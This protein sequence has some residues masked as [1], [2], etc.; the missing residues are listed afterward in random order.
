MCPAV[1]AVQNIGGIGNVTFLPPVDVDATPLAFDTGPG[2]ASIDWAALQATAGAQTFIATARWPPRVGWWRRGGQLA[3]A[4]YFAQSPPKTTG[5]ELFSAELAQTW[6]AAA[7]EQQSNDP[8]FVA[9]VTASTAASIADAY[10]RFAPGVVAQVIVGG[11]GARNPAL[12]EMLRQRLAAGWAMRSKSARTRRWAS[13]A[14]PRRRW[15]LPCSPI[16]ASTAGRECSGLHRR[17]AIADP[18]PD[19]RAWRSQAD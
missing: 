14:T 17:A 10:A 18:G 15:R 5:R 11:G 3:G 13:M 19:C 12:M 6:R 7:A 16:S 9:T 4:P 1:G 2:N 8:D